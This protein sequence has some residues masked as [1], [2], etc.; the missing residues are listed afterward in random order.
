MTNNANRNV[1]QAIYNQPNDADYMVSFSDDFSV[2]IYTD[3][4]ELGLDM[5][6]ED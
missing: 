5:N 2:A 1:P 4:D 3:I 6:I